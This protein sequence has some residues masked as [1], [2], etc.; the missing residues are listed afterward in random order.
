MLGI[1][2]LKEAFGHRAPRS[3]SPL[4][5]S[6]FIEQD[7]TRLCIQYAAPET[8]DAVPQP[9]D[10][11]E[12]AMRVALLEELL[13]S[14]QATLERRREQDAMILE[15]RWRPADWRQSPLP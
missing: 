5:L 11:L 7:V 8:S 13:E 12:E 6:V 3:G 14:L 10:E 4:Q 1:T 15:L 2:A 9:K